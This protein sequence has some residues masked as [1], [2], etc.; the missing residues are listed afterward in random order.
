MKKMRL[1]LALF[2]GVVVL[3]TSLGSYALSSEPVKTT[4]KDT[5][6][7]NE[8]FSVTIPKGWEGNDSQWSG[9]VARFHEMDIY[10][11]FDEGAWVSIVR[12]STKPFNWESPKQAAEL[13]TALKELPPDEALKYNIELDPNYLGVIGEQDSIEIG[14]C[15]AYLTVYKYQADEDTLLDFQ[16]C[17]ITPWDNQLY[18]VNHNTYYSTMNMNPQIG[19]ECYDIIES[20]RFKRKE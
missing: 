18:Y 4:K 5:V 14:G 16:F 12:S 2:L 13:S 8:S 10:N 17:V 1:L 15:P 7:S 20:I 9:P 19:D 6:Y 11:K 3:S